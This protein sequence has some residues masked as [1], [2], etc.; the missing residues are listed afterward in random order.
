MSTL[1]GQNFLGITTPDVNFKRRHHLYIK[2]EGIF[3]NVNF[4]KI[5]GVKNAKHNCRFDFSLKML[6]NDYSNL[7]RLTYQL[8]AINSML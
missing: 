5:S 6:F 2:T 4:Q 3:K 7:L 8:C 1:G